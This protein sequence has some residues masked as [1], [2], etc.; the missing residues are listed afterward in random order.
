[1]LKTNSKKA[2]QN[3]RKYICDHVNFSE[4]AYIA[5]LEE[6][7]LHGRSIDMFTVYA[8]AIDASFFKEMVYLNNENKTNKEFFVDWCEA[9][10][11]VLDTKYYTNRS[12]I[13]DLGDILEE[14]ESEKSRFTESQA[15]DMLTHLIYREVKKVTSKGG[16]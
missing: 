9:L 12:A 5:K 3:I 7:N 1:M 2:I 4:Y 16:K 15:C 10:P 13:D 14:S 6:D 8:Y 11:T